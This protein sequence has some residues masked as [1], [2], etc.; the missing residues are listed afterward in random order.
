[1]ILM[2]ILTGKNP[3]EY[4]CWWSPIDSHSVTVVGVSEAANIDGSFSVDYINSSHGKKEQ[5]M[6]YSDVRD[7]SAKKGYGSLG[8]WVHERP[9]LNVASGSLYLSTYDQPWNARTII[10]LHYGIYRK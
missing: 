2:S 1:M 7:F 10:Y 6:L 3:M 8:E 5:M 9:F 4:T